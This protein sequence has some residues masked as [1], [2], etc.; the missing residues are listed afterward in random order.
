MTLSLVNGG[1]PNADGLFLS[2]VVA[3]DRALGAGLLREAARNENGDLKNLF[4]KVA[5]ASQR[6]VAAIA[7]LEEKKK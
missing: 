5:S 1:T 7:A 4:A 2:G 3:R 6:R